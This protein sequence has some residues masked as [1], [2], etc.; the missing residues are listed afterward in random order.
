MDSVH[1]PLL[2]ESFKFINDCSRRGRARPA[3]K[4]FAE[5]DSINKPQEAEPASLRLPR[6]LAPVPSGPVGAYLARPRRLGGCCARRCVQASVSPRAWCPVAKLCGRM[7]SGF[8]HTRAL[9]AGRLRLLS[10]SPASPRL[11]FPHPGSSSFGDAPL[12]PPWSLGGPLGVREARRDGAGRGG[13][14]GVGRIL[15]R[16][17]RDELPS[18]PSGGK[19]G[20]AGLQTLARERRAGPQARPARV[21]RSSPA[22]PPLLQRLAGSPPVAVPTRVPGAPET[23]GG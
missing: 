14:A 2:Q 9:G 19:L 18:L 15:P 4:H 21:Q 17:R 11:P 23:R 8:R 13:A 20:R 3:R 12:P 7:A 6:C 10:K 16:P 1:S 5:L 22:R